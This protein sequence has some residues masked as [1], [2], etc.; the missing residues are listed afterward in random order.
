M[1][2]LA[3]E[4]K[5]LVANLISAAEVA[6]AQQNGHLAKLRGGFQPQ[7]RKPQGA[8]DRITGT[9]GAGKSS[10]TDELIVRILHDLKQVRVAV[11]SCDPSRRKTGGALLGDRIRM[12]AIGQ[13]P[14]LHA[15]GSPP[16]ARPRD[17][18]ALS[19]AILAVKAAAMIW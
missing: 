13:P 3:P 1:D 8:G 16:A 12:N 7:N 14:G 15:L 2:A 9:G 18:E 6:K 4:N 17:P 10:L 5:R 19:D 11:L